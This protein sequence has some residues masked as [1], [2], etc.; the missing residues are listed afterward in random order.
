M[1]G[2]K[3]G[4]NDSLDEK[5]VPQLQYSVASSRADLGM[6]NQTGLIS[7]LATK[8]VEPTQICLHC[9]R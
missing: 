9:Q 1:I 4:W 2:P 8:S 6:M 3:S 5:P 7:F